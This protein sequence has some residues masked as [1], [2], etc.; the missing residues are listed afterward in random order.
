MQ[1]LHV[2][3]NSSVQLN[4]QMC[5]CCNGFN[6]SKR[7]ALLL[8]GG[9]KSDCIAVFLLLYL[10][11]LQ[12]F[13]D[14]MVSS[15]SLFS[16]SLLEVGA[17]VCVSASGTSLLFI[18]ALAHSRELRAKWSLRFLTTETVLWFCDSVIHIA[19]VPWRAAEPKNTSNFHPFS[20][21]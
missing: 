3:C 21:H 11:L 12:A 17:A 8:P 20:C 18:L 5:C 13:L 1:C 7:T 14:H 6:Y 16:F 4:T 9:N 15:V 10:L 2:D 19:K